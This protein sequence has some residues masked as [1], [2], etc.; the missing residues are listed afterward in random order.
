MQNF[1]FEYLLAEVGVTKMEGMYAVEGES[2][3][4]R[5][6]RYKVLFRTN[7]VVAELRD[8]RY[9][10]VSN[11][12]LLGKLLDRNIGFRWVYCMPPDLWA[13][14]ERFCRQTVTSG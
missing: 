12:F 11:I 6:Q 14:F 9:V 5:V 4:E 2:S 10:A 1:F 3:F 13:R 8:G 7:V